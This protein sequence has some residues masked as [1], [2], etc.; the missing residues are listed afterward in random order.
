[1]TSAQET[2][3]QD[4]LRLLVLFHYVISALMALWGSF[5]LL[6]VALG[7]AIAMGASGFGAGKE[8]PPAFFGWFFA[9]FGALFVLVGWTLAITV[10]MGARALKEHRRHT[11]CIVVAA[12]EAATCVPFGTVLGVFTIIVLS[13]PTV[14]ALFAR[15]VP[16]A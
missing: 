12:I 5:P 4:H 14:K 15:E 8:A 3:D 10:F 6:H 7:L 13:R 1:M 16:A 9:G 11:F 2:Q